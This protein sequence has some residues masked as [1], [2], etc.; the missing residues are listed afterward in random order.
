VA[1][2]MGTEDAVAAADEVAEV[3]ADAA[4][5]VDVVAAPAVSADVVA[6]PEG[7]VDPVVLVEVAVM[8]ATAVVATDAQESALENRQ[9]HFQHSQCCSARCWL[10][11]S[12]NRPSRTQRA[13]PKNF[14]TL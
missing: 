2:E 10:R 11:H 13:A 8:D 12:H 3:A 6:E 4:V 1:V 7:A 9:A 14:V 5:P